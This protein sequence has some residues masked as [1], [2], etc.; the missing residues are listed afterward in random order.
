VHGVSDKKRVCAIQNS[1]YLRLVARLRI[2][3]NSRSQST[4]LATVAQ[5]SQLPRLTLAVE[6][7]RCIIG[8]QITATCNRRGN[9]T[10]L[11]FRLLENNPAKAR[12]SS[13][14]AL[15]TMKSEKN[16]SVVKGHSMRVTHIAKQA[17]RPS[18][19]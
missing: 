10:V 2:L 11:H 4:E 13:E 12:R 15:K 8:T 17:R 3:L 6:N 5:R 14:L 19:G 16:T 1:T 7:A 9:S 18:R